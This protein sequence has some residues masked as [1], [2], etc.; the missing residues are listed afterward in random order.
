MHNQFLFLKLSY[1]RKKF[2]FLRQKEMETVATHFDKRVW[3]SGI[4]YILFA[5]AYDD[6]RKCS[7]TFIINK[8]FFFAS[9]SP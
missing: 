2:T 3:F 1:L 6:T 9:L 7:S 5:Q 8:L 4:L